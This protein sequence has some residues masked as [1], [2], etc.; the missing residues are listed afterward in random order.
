MKILT[1]KSYI[2]GGLVVIAL[3]LVI[4]FTF[5]N[6]ATVNISVN[7]KDAQVLLNNAPQLVN[8]SGISKSSHLAGKYT[9]RVEA[10]GYIPYTESVTLKG[11]S[12]F[13]KT[14]ELKPLPKLS[15]LDENATL[16]EKYGDNQASYLGDNKTTLYTVSAG[17]ND[18][19]VLESNDKKA[20]TPAVFAS[21]D[22]MIFSPDKQ[23]A[24]LKIG[25]DL[26]LYDFNRYDILTQ[27]MRKISSNVGDVV[28]A[29]DQ[30][31]IAYFYAPLSGERSL[32]FAD[33]LNANPVR[34]ASLPEMTDPILHWSSEGDQ[35]LIIPRNTKSADNKIN[36]FDVF[37]RQ[38]TTLT[39][40]GSVLD[41][42]FVLSGQ[43]IIYFT[44]SNDPSN[45]I[46]SDMSI[47]DLDGQN[48]ESMKLK[49]YPTQISIEY[50]SKLL[51]V[52]HLSGKERVML[53][54][55]NNKDMT[56]VSFEKPSNFQINSLFLSTDNKVLYIA[57]NNSLYATE[58]ADTNY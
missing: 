50:D 5:L 42:R 21:V 7:P 47:M 40:F 45:P 10:N 9:L 6:K 1:Q 12:S 51:F 16:A 36:I 38:L 13:K 23:L 25:T 35:I 33:V 46:K 3:A 29:P 28:W 24:L 4:Y 31:R 15:V 19:N 30:S 56:E 37:T 17:L 11:G 22:K 27:E 34:V 18:K 8:N 54:D 14:L 52:T 58:Y 20:M 49:V 57:G 48:K 26:Y 2:F 43:K 55:L 39:D 53:L 44:S 32:I 41:A